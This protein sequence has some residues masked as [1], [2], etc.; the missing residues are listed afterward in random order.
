MWYISKN[1]TSSLI[2]DTMADAAEKL[3]VLKSEYERMCTEIRSVEANNEK[4]VAFGLSIITAAFAVG[5]AQHVCEIFFII[6]IAITGVFFY[7]VLMYTFVFSMGGYKAFL[8][9][10]LNELMG[11]QFL[12]WEQLV[13]VRQRD[14][15]VRPALVS[16]Y[17]LIAGVLT[18]VSV[19]GIMTKYGFSAGMIELLVVLLLLMVL[20]LSLMRMEAMYQ[21]IYSSAKKLYRDGSS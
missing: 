6:P 4:T 7:A 18:Y 11:S 15:M 21:R 19:T 16:I 13:Q 14:N 12:L 5:A 10:R 17:L 9:E 8:E 3:S 20:L 2:P 1:S